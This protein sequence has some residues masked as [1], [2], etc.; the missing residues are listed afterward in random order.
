VSEE[1]NGH[2]AP[3]GREE[4]S[5]ENDPVTK[6]FIKQEL[7]QELEALEGWLD[8]KLDEKL[9]SVLKAIGAEFS[10]FRT[11][12]GQR[13]DRIEVRLDKQGGL[14]QSGSRA[15]TRFVE[16]SESTDITLSRYDRRL[17]EFER[18]LERLEKPAA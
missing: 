10:Q 17:A 15:I 3:D 18:R 12:L 4:V 7:K 5:D 9:D 8:A 14:M 1:S 16:W 2:D 11:E 6:G 13:F